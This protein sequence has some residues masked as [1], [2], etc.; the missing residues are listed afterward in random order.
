MTLEMYLNL[1]HDMSY[2][3][4]FCILYALISAKFSGDLK[5]TKEV[6]EKEPNQQTESH[7]L[8]QQHQHQ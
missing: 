3:L 7:A 1:K 2:P 5:Q 8:A 6:K 4:K